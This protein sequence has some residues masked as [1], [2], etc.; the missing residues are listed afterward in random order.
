MGYQIWSGY[1]E[2]IHSAETR[3]QD[4]SAILEDRLDATLRRADADLTQ[5]AHTIPV[6]A[7]SQ[8]AVPRYARELDADLDYRLFKFMEIAG[9]RVFDRRGDMLY[10]S[11]SARTPRVN[12]ADR[13]YFRQQRD[14]PKAGLLFSEVITSRNTGRP[15]IVLSRALTDEHSTFL[16][17]VI[18]QVELDRFQALFQS[19]SIG[20][21]GVIVW[22]RSDDQRLILRWPTLAS[23]VN[24]P[25]EPQHPIVK[26]MA[27]GVRKA[28]LQFAAQTDGIQRIFSY[29]ALEGYPFYV[30][31]GIAR[32]DVLA[33]WRMRSLTIGALALLFLGMLAWLLFRLRRA[34][35]C[36]TLA[37]SELTESEANFR[38]M[39]DSMLEGCQIV[40]F[41]WRY[42]YLNDAAQKHNRRPREDLLG[43]TVMEC[44]PGITATEVFAL[45]KSCME[46]RTT[47]HL[48]TE[49]IFPDGHKGWFSLII[50]PVP[51]GIALYS[52]DIAERRQA[53][54]TLRQLNQELEIK[55]AARTTELEQTNT[56]L[57]TKQEE[58][59]SVVFH[60][61]DCVITIDDKGIIL[62]A[63][64][65]VEKIFGYTLDEVLGQNISMLMPEP[66]RGAHDGYI[67]NYR[68]NGQ[69]RIIGIGRE[70]EGL[71]KNGERIAL[72]LAISEYSVHGERFFT[73]TLRDIRDRVRIMKDLKQ[74]QLYAEQANQAKS[75]FLAAMSH[76]IRTPMNGVIGMVDVL[77]QTSLKGHQVEILDIIRDSAFSLL[78]I[79]EDILDFSKIEA[80]K[81]EIECAPTALAEVVEKVCVM[82]D[83]LAEK[84]EVEL[85]LFTDPAIPAAVLGDAQRLRQIVINLAS[86]AIKFSSGQDQP[87]RVS[88]QAVLVERDAERVVVE[89]RVTDNGIGMDQEILARLFSPFTQ[90]DIT[91]T[92]RFGGTGLG[93]SI[94]R[95]LAQLMGGEIS[96]HSTA[97]QGSTFTVR[98]PFVPVPAPSVDSATSTLVTG[99]SCLVVGG[100]AGLADYLAAYLVSAGALVEQVPN[101]AAARERVALPS[102][103][104]EA[105]LIDAGNTPP[106]TEELRAIT[107]ARP[108][109]EIH[110]V[111]IGRGKRR[112][113]DRQDAD[114]RVQVDG[115]VLTRQ[116]V[117]QAVAIATG[118]MQAEMVMPPANNGE[119]NV[120]APS[121]ADAVRQGRLILVAEDNETNQKVILR[122]LALLGFAADVVSDGEEALE[123]WRSGDYVLLLSDLHMPKMDGYALTAAI[124]AAENSDRHGVIIALT[125]NALKGEA[126]R[127]RAAGMD[128]YLSKPA[129]LA[130][131]QTMLKK[132]LPDADPAIQPTA[133]P[134][135]AAMT[136][137]QGCAPIPLD[138]RVLKALVGDDPETIRDF[139]RDF[140]AS[141][142]AIATELSTACAA[143]QATQVTAL[144]HKLKSSARSVGALALGELC[145][146]LEAAGKAATVDALGALHAR[147]AVEMVAVDE[148][149]RA[150]TTDDIDREKP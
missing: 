102:S 70:I 115:N 108:E 35:A 73:G 2:A 71:H 120:T 16:G 85:T 39:L 55:V 138:V 58:L 147:F 129:T 34:V 111:V 72:D 48:E 22:R 38:K 97:G 4:Y 5:L 41:D 122:Q 81:L 45:E 86:N 9:F 110:L 77:H 78:D 61:V 19:L 32:D 14:D 121:R 64:P 33:E 133:Q 40:D 28:T 113:P 90:A 87:G 135:A 37:L 100:A 127:C 66:H 10:T 117:L 128:D 130:D 119:A 109:R 42:R 27:T 25:L 141:A 139:L 8:Q 124:R 54:E 84:K 82:L 112:R 104:Y 148:A 83:H 142:T 57:L 26:Q 94:A 50:Q 74:A 145:A 118:R 105:C 43:R 140:R 101:L 20:P 52:D 99:L 137:A 24:I 47:H 126:L 51:E 114:Q 68:R 49:F 123:R 23:E 107:T 36:E 76:E 30:N 15:V 125:A 65:M 88:V 13:D 69:A 143:G 91:T 62:S 89:I 3:T 136:P 46:Q 116:T 7:L 103:R 12:I 134:D 79:I 80:G 6:A 131:L 98:L 149:L 144:A 96:V 67:E 18:A 95:N 21:Q 59:R 11:A 106:L 92:R 93:L 56:E 60:M 44:W 53:E 63:N 29:R 31:V 132:W 1:Q 150:L 146:E 75:N 17:T